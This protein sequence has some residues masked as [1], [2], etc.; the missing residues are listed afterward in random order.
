[1]RSL[2]P[3]RKRSLK[4]EMMDCPDLHPHLHEHALKGLRRINL[5]S[6]A[7]PQIF[8]VL[9]NFSLKYGPLKILDVATGAGDVPIQ[10][11]E[12]ARHKGLA[13]E[14]HACDKSETALKYAEEE[15][16]KRK[17][18]V[19][20]F[21]MDVERDSF[22]QEYDVIVNSLFL[23]HLSMLQTLRFIKKIAQAAR[24][25]IILNDLQRSLPGLVVAEAGCRLLTSSSVVHYDGPQSVRAAYT[26]RE[27]RRLAERAGL[28]NV[29]IKTA[30]P[31]R[32]QLIWQRNDS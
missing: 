5:M 3:V 28:R 20:F 9:K 1:M 26:V 17:T 23:H 31:F 14:V 10:L 8:N 25:G 16:R 6:Q 15:A 13:F 7:A 27:I 32:Y 22:P 12:L 29:K 18:L 24:H 19:R 4:P 2:S 21:Q 11:W 30:W